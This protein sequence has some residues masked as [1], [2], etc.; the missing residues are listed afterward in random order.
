M[1]DLAFMLIAINELADSFP[2]GFTTEQALSACDLQPT[3]AA[4]VAMH[5]RLDASGFVLKRAAYAPRPKLWVRG[6]TSYGKPSVVLYG[7]QGSG[8]STVARRLAVRLGL[9]RVV[10]PADVLPRGEVPLQGAVLIVTDRSPNG[11]TGR[12]IH[13]TE[14][15]KLLGISSPAQL[16]PSN[17]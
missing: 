10:D 14:A 2:D 3:R 1:S 11:F 6:P 4:N 5:T 15:C 16:N 12:R 7:P 8:K 13:I 17:H 9:H